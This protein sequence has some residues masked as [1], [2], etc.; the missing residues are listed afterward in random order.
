MISQQ[1][2]CGTLI[3]VAS[4]SYLWGQG[5]SLVVPEDLGPEESAFCPFDD[6][7]V[8]GLRWVVHD[9]SA[10]RWKVK[11]LIHRNSRE[12]HFFVVN[13]RVDSSVPYKVD[14]PLF[15]FILTET[16]SCREV[17]KLVVSNHQSNGG[18]CLG[19]STHLMSI[20]WWILQ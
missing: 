18:K 12:T 4:N 13:L 8:H 2:H 16:Q 5:W 15:P 19:C 1:Q 10:L 7:L 9:H 17:P 11:G 14:D 6:L 3:S 20:R